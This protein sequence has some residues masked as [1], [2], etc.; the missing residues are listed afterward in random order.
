M[1]DNTTAPGAEPASTALQSQTNPPDQ[2]L[3]AEDDVFFRRV[4]TQVLL[5]S[6]YAVDAAA[7]GAA[8]WRALNTERYDL[9]ITDN[10]MPKVSGI[11]LLK[12]LHGARMTL[13]VIMATAALPEEEFTR[14]PW[15]QPAA[16]LLKPYTGEEMLRIVK[17]V[18]READRTANGAQPTMD[19]DMK[20]NKISQAGE[21]AN[22]P[23]QHPT[24]AS[25]HILVVDEDSDLRRL[26]AEALAGLGYHVDAAEDGAAAWEALKAN[27][28]HLM[29]TEHEMPN[30]T[31]VEL[32]K[33]VRAAHM[34][35]PVVMAAGRL[36]THELAR[37]PSL[38]LAATL[39]KPFPVNALLDTVQNVL[40]ATDSPHEQIEPGRAWS[41]QPSGD[42]LWL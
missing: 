8:A 28:Y 38:Q 25:H 3:V 32:V 15:L 26:Y 23:R 17:K 19:Y 37:N 36:P 41:N 30:L 13:P 33:M 14:Y 31:G 10:G 29:I 24:K 21:P 35:V 27:R 34:A 39:S 2:I 16:T 22:A 7:D 9:L 20:D 12:K 5:R 6:G 18:L 4:N 11:E 42:G 40:R 1:K